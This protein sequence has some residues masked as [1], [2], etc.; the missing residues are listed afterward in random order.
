VPAPSAHISALFVY[1][2]K[3]CRGIA[4][5]EARLDARGLTHDREWMVVDEHGRFLTQ[6]E[7][8]RLA[9][10][11]TELTTTT[12]R[13]TTAGMPALV[14]ALAARSATRLPV[15]VWNHQGEAE[16]GGEEAARWLTQAIGSAARLVRAPQQMPRESNALYRGGTPAPINFPDGYPILICNTASLADLNA[17]MGT[18]GPVPMSRFRPN[19]VVDGWPAYQEDQLRQ[20]D[21]G[22]VRLRLVKACTRCATTTVDQ[23]TGELAANPLPHLKAYRFD[24]ALLGVTFGQNAVIESGIG[25]ELRV[26]EAVHALA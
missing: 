15:Q 23:L 14:I 26:G 6:R 4:L 3:S 17:R 20:L 8:P 9:R 21:I 12:L 19:I 24:K 1:P 10:I 2:I 16:D 25:A 7:Y 22:G 18:D 5:Q 13:L 11:E